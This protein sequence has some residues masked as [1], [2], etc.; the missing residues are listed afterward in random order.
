MKRKRI[1]IEAIFSVF[2]LVCTPVL[3]TLLQEE[4]LIPNSNI[5]KGTKVDQ[6]E[7]LFQ[8]ILDIANNR[9]IQKIIMNYE[10]RRGGFFNSGVRFLVIT[11]HF[12]T[13]L[14]LNAVYHIGLI[15]SRTVGASR[16]HS[17]PERYQV[18][19]Q[20]IQDEI[21]AVIEKDA[22]LK[23]EIT[24]LSNSKCDCENNTGVKPWNFPILCSF[25][26]VLFKILENMPSPFPVPPL[27]L[28]F[29]FIYLQLGC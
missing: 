23:A 17:M 11:P 18:S 13:K 28:F 25:L 19:S 2:I 9:E 12:F 15:F 29:Y 22:T 14:E 16:M 1:I 3:A 24:Q 10:M 7:L 6:K 4:H 26:Y 5:G 8:V 20:G 27:A 21:T